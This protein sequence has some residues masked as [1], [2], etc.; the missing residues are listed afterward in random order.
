M[1]LVATHPGVS[2]ED[3]QAATDFELLVAPELSTSEPPSSVE[4]E[5]MREIDPTEM[6][7]G[8]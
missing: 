3:V 5:K 7:I 6:V 2:V 4:L 8:K 1:R